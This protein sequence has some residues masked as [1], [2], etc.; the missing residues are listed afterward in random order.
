MDT[1]ERCIVIYVFLLLVIR[2]SGRR[3]L[4]ELTAFDFVLLLIIGETA[5]T[6]ILGDDLSIT[7]GVLS[8]LTLVTIEVG[9]SL[10]KQRWRVIERWVDG[11]PTILVEDGQPFQ[12]RLDRSRVDVEDVLEAARKKQGLE[13]MEQ[14]KY[15][16]LER[17]GSINIISGRGDGG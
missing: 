15:A 13:R 11:L 17:D 7:S 16:V 1:V 14:I 5:G 10:A 8:I 3:T 9:L 12:D 6:T 2:V 4:G